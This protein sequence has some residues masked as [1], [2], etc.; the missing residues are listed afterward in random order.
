MGFQSPKYC[1]Q[2]IYFAVLTIIAVHM[3]METG[4]S[5]VNQDYCYRFYLDTSGNLTGPYKSMY[6]AIQPTC[7]KVV[8]D[9]NSTAR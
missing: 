8:I 7:Q 5:Y 3:V 1:I 2:F 9:D 4:L 6:D